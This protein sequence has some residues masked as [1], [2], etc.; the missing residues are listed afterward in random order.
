MT[1]PEST[2]ACSV[3]KSG[4]SWSVERQV[5]TSGMYAHATD[6]LHANALARR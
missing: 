2:P 5:A 4:R 6:R 1:F 3:A